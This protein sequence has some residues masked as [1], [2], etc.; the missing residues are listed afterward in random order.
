VLADDLS[1]AQMGRLK[2]T[3]SVELTDRHLE[4]L[5]SWDD[6]MFAVVAHVQKPTTRMTKDGD[7]IVDWVLTVQ[8]MD[9]ILAKAVQEHIEAS[10][11]WE[12][13]APRLPFPEREEG[14]A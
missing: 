2:I 1:R 10:L 13:A 14:A 3:G 4:V 9:V 5:N 12:P 11:G 7:I 6:F 8:D